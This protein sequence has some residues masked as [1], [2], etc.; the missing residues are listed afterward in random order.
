MTTTWWDDARVV[1]VA[2]RATFLTL[3]AVSSSDDGLWRC[4]PCARKAQ[5]SYWWERAQAHA[6]PTKDYTR[7]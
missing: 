2:C 5:S 1:C 3:D 6:C 7:T 4:K